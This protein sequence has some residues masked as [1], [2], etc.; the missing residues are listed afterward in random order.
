MKN[1][2]LKL[3]YSPDYANIST[4][5]VCTCRL[6]VVSVASGVL[7]GITNEAL[8]GDERFQCTNK[9]V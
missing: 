1:M 3:K 9:G 8:P 6:A 7:Q 2:E 4:E 5:E